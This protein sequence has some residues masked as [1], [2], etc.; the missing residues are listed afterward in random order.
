MQLRVSVWAVGGGAG[1]LA[2]V[3]KAAPAAETSETGGLHT[4]E[5]S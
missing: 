5:A 4:L 2:R 1:R 3:A